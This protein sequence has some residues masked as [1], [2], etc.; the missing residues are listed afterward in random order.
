MGG[1]T[2]LVS[3]VVKRDIE[4]DP[5]THLDVIG[6]GHEGSVELLQPA[7]QLSC[8]LLFGKLLCGDQSGLSELD[9]LVALSAINLEV[10]VSHCEAVLLPPGGNLG[11]P[12]GSR[13]VAV[14]LFTGQGQ[15][16]QTVPTNCVSP[17]V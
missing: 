4:V 2:G 10:E 5:A 7:S 14:E 9:K 11:P 3:V 13:L 17:Y 16:C 8:H 12:V 1:L 15:L 6:V